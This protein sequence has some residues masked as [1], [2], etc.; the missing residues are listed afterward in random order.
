MGTAH[1]LPLPTPVLIHQSLNPALS[2]LVHMPGLTPGS[3]SLSGCPLRHEC[4]VGSW[5][6]TLL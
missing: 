1:T 3:P 2:L 4:E 6:H 5:V